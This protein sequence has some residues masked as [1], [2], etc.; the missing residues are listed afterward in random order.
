VSFL[1]GVFG[2]ASVGLVVASIMVAAA[3][4]PAV[5]AATLEGSTVPVESPVS[6]DPEETVYGT[7]E[8][9]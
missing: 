7:P 2:G 4:P 9:F 1:I 3:A 6:D 8:G 5:D